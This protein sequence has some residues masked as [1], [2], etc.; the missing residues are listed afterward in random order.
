MR[1]FIFVFILSI[2]FIVFSAFL[3]NTYVLQKGYFNIK[4]KNSP[5]PL[6]NDVLPKPALSIYTDYSKDNYDKA[7]EFKSVLV[8]YFTSN[9]CSECIAQEEINKE[10]F[11]EIN[12]QDVVFLKIHILDS[13]TTTE[14]DAL[15]K[16]FDVKKENTFVFLDKTGAV[17]LK[18]VGELT[19][20]QLKA[21]IMKVGDFK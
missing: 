3:Y 15:A 20:E 11:S 1:K 10:V 18:Y 6:V 4:N 2:L 14:T 19:N 13:E 17:V 16:K 5:E 9:W 12:N 21:D 8:L 7:L